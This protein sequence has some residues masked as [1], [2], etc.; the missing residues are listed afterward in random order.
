MGRVAT[1]RDIDM[2]RDLFR[3]EMSAFRHEL[4]AEWKDDPRVATLALFGANV[5]LA[6]LAFAA[7]H[8]I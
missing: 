2:L 6:A 5:T 8:L 1:K 4:R 7:A 3:L